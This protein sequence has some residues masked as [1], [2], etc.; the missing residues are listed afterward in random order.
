MIPKVVKPR[1]VTVFKHISLCSVIYRS[2][3]KIKTNRLKQ[4]S[5]KVMFPTQ[6]AFIPNKLIMD[7]IIIGYEYP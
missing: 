6:N 7:K 1:D 5:Y 2:I 3:T 4:I